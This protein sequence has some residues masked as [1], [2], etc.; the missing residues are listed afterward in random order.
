MPD[1]W[2]GVDT[3]LA[4]VP[5]NKTPLVDATDGATIED[6]IAYDATGMSL[7]WNF[8][9]T[10]G[11]F[12]STAV[13][14]TTGGAYDWAE[15]TADKG[16]YSIEIPAS[17]GAS[18]N[19]D[20]EGFGWFTGKCDATL[21]WTGP[22][23]G[24]RAAG[25]NNMLIDSAYSETRGLAGTALPA[26]AAD[27]AGGLPISDAG[28]LDLDT[29]DSNITALLAG[30]N[31]MKLWSGTFTSANAT[32]VTMADEADANAIYVGARVIVVL[33]SGT[34]CNGRLYFG[35]VGASRVITVDPAFSADG[36]DTPSGTIV[37]AVYAT[38]KS[39][40]SSTPYVQLPDGHVTAAKLGADCITADKI[41]DD[42]IVAANLATG[43]IT[44]DAFAADA[45]VAAT[46][47]TGALTADAFAADALV[48]ATFAT[49]SIT[50]DALADDAIAEINATVDTA[51]S[52]YDAA[53]GT[54][55]AAV[56]T[57]IDTAQADLDILTGT[58]G[59][60]LATAQGNYAPNVVV[61]DAAGTLA[62]LVGALTDA[63]AE[64][65]VT[66]TDT[67]MAYVKQIV[68]AEIA[69]ATELA[70][71]GTIPALDGGAQTIGA[72]IGKLAD[73]N[74]GADFDA[75][76]DSLERLAN[77]APMGT[78]MRGTDGANITVPDAAGT[79]AG[80]IGSLNTDLVTDLADGSIADIGG[81]DVSELNAI[82]DDLLNDGRLDLLID[83]IKAVT[84]VIPDAGALT[85]INTNTARLTATRAQIID[86]W[87]N[88]GRLD[89][90]LDSVITAIA[91]LPDAA[92]INAEVV[93]VI[94]TDTSAEPAQGA[95][96]ATASLRTKIDWLYKYRRN[97]KTQTATQF[98][99]YN[100][101]GDTVDHK[102]TI[103]DDGDTATFGELGTGP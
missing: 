89:L 17:G 101:A 8:F 53:T 33:V 102:A 79:V 39:P 31:D 44:A 48:A 32:T 88:G 42:A 29:L 30:L 34:N 70:K 5:V 77:T 82:V 56:D 4:E 81:I 1:L 40:T 100:D 15:H 97:L 98:S 14:P 50:A 37:G 25:L 21:P 43:A 7:V 6:A 26:V 96:P 51:L 92:A 62:A 3:A 75:E 28:A 69:A 16:M 61:P 74:G 59:V 36:G 13:T 24:F 45:I 10:G 91:A 94:N 71:I 55:L 20:T 68:T 35:T 41:A 72:A 80:L 93:D 84:D 67:I 83:A 64:G 57:K 9:T 23:I 60:T 87:V 95:A 99:L 54:E 85:T 19:N 86:D 90:L 103:S 22:T 18:I 73:D 49:D 2:A 65:A 63:A 11:G 78:A 27:G 12:S 52:D 58:D 76:T 38:A 47:A 46:L 66:D